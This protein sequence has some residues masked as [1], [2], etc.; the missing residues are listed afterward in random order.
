M[1][2]ISFNSGY[3][4]YCINDD[5]NAVI[6]INTTD[7]HIIDRITQAKK[8]LNEIMS[9]YSAINENDVTSDE[10]VK[11]MSEA[12]KKIREQINYVFGSDVCSAAFGITSCLSPVGGQPLFMNFLD[13]VLPIIE[14]DVLA[15]RNATS[16]NIQKYTSQLKK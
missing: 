8:K 3:K 15:E 4:T 13:A 1:E 12:E 9:E 5:E 2:K 7:I 16:K 11:L 10:A 14:K 6:R